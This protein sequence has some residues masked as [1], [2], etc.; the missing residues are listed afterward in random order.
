MSSIIINQMPLRRDRFH[1]LYFIESSILLKLFYII[2]LKV[3]KEIFLALILK[4]KYNIQNN[5]LKVK[6]F[7]NW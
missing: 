6:K 3:D 7:N 4:S 2:L 1:N 5:I